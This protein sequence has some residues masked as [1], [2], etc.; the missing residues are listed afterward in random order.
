MKCSIPERHRNRTLKYSVQKSTGRTEMN[1]ISYGGYAIYLHS[2]QAFSSPTQ[3]PVSPWLSPGAMMTTT[4]P[5]GMM[6]R[7][8]AL[9]T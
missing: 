5:L 4:T 7:A 3:S 8:W 6:L 9:Y 1:E 2:K